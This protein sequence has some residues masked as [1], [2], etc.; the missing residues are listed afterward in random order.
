MNTFLLILYVVLA[1]FVGNLDFGYI[2]VRLKEGK[3]IRT[4]GSGNPGTANVLRNYG[5]KMAIAVF[6]GDFLKGA[7]VV[8]VAKL[9]GITGWWL[10]AAA[11][12]VVLGHN[13]PV[14][15]K[16]KG[17]KGVATTI[18]VLTF[19]DF[20]V[21]IYPLTVG[22]SVAYLTRIISVGSMAG[23]C[24]YPFFLYL[25]TGTT[26]YELLTLGIVLALF[27]LFQHRSN[28][29]RLLHGEEKPAVKQPSER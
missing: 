17:G 3:D 14:L 10:M 28:I 5:K 16:F 20:A 1:Y 9:L 24:S 12:A 4:E 21:G 18:G 19:M 2:I 13:Y 7:A 26:E 22:L 27:N 15:L 29:V 25:Y 23:V 11:F 6:A 8:I